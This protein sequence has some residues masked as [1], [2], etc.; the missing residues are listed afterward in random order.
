MCWT[1]GGGDGVVGGVA[2]DGVFGR[3]SRWWL[4]GSWT[5][6]DRMIGGPSS[7]GKSSAIGGCSDGGASDK[8]VSET[9]RLISRALEDWRS[10]NLRFVGFAGDDHDSLGFRSQIVNGS[11][12]VYSG[13]NAG[14]GGVVVD[15]CMLNCV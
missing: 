14:D 9:A 8:K 6:T 4:F 5:V 15:A 7:G 10:S 3:S 1:A 12:A 13:L 11:F 2:V